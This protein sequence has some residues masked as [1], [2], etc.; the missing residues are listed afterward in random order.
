ML[1][2]TNLIKQWSFSALKQVKTFLTTAW[3]VSKYGVFSGPYF[4]VFGLNM[5]I[6]GVNLPIQSKYGKIL[7]R[8]NSVFWHFLSSEYLQ[9]YPT[10]NLD[11][12]ASFCL[13]ETRKRG[14]LLKIALGTK[15]AYRVTHLMMLHMHENKTKPSDIKNIY[16][17]F[18]SKE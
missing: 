13:R 16:F 10:E 11:Y 5:K 7:T 14:L 1:P 6:H 15:L 4:S 12:S 9:H 2:T 17:H 18:I 8:K 3:K